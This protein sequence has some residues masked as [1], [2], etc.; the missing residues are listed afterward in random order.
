MRD[1]PLL[2]THCAV[3]VFWQQLDLGA[4]PLLEPLIGW[5]GK[6]SLKIDAKAGFNGFH[7]L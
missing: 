1:S 5:L 6:P 7:L 2:F 3:V 4:E